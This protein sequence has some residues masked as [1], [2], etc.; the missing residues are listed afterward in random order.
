MASGG[1]QRLQKAL[2]AAGAGSRRSC[3]KLI[4]GGRV[5]VNGEIA[6]LGTSVNPLTDSVTIDGRPVDLRTAR[7][8]CII[9]NKPRGYITTRRDPHG[10]KTVM[11]LVGEDIPALHPV[12]RLD[13]DTEGLLLLT[14]DGSLTYRLTHPRHEVDKTYE[15]T[16]SGIPGEEALEALREGI[17]LEEGVTSPAAVRVLM[18]R[19]GRAVVEITVHQGWKRQIRRMFEAVGHPVLRLK[20]TRY[21]FLELGR[22]RPGEWRRL[23]DDEIERL[24]ESGRRSA[25]ALRRRRTWRHNT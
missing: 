13:C 17:R 5:R 4:A 10:R 15:A 12:G 9:L 18:K 16:V 24:R 6:T 11:D 23:T 20:R 21:A 3:E 25:A 8:V 2:A 14:N 1:L 22:L 7:R 19:G